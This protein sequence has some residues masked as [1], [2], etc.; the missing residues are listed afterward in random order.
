MIISQGLIYLLDIKN[1]QGDCY[2]NSD[3]LYSVAT[4][5]EYKN[6]VDQLK[7][8]ATLFRQLLQNQKQNYLVDASVIFINPEFT[9]YQAP[10]DQPIILPTQINRFL[11]D[12]NKTSSELNE[13]HKKLA[14][15]LISLHQTKNPFTILP[16][17]NYDQ[18][19]KGIYCKACKSFLVS[20]KNY[21]FVCK[22]CGGHEKVS[23]AI[24]RNVNEFNLLFPDRKIT[25]QSIYDWCKVDL[26]KKTFCRILKKNYTTVGNTRDTYYV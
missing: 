4:K 22:N 19:H 21:N 1:Y 12:S 18:L 7:R 3:K 11:R 10:L 5:R 23:L 14:Q 9:L 25:T 15:T 20:I 16:K 26:N 2:L 6:P 24:L 13:G 8:S 17:Y